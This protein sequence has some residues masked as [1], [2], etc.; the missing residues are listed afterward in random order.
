MH[1]YAFRNTYAFTHTYAFRHMCMW[2]EDNLVSF[3]GSY[4][5]CFFETFSH[6]ESFY[7]T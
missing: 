6:G 5:H 1:T 7:F 3:L 2:S 4:P